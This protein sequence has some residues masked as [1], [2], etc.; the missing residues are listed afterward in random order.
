MPRGA[1]VQ[2]VVSYTPA[3]YDQVVG[4]SNPLND[5][6]K[7]DLEEIKEDLGSGNYSD[8]DSYVEMN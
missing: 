1:H 7:E 3:D 8:E 6:Q 4:V 2:G 5:M